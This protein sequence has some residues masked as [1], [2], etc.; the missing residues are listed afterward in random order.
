[1]KF[2]IDD[3]HSKL[4]LYVVKVKRSISKYNVILSTYKSVK[5]LSLT[6]EH[7]FIS[8]LIVYNTWEELDREAYPS[9]TFAELDIEYLLDK[10]FILKSARAKFLN[11][12]AEF[13]E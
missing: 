12:V 8:D 11:E 9:I 2:E 7:G 4:M 6:R 3:K 10:L 1:M 5:D 13:M